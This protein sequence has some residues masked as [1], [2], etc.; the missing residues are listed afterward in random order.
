MGDSGITSLVHRLSQPFQDGLM[1]PS[2]NMSFL[3]KSIQT[4]VLHG[5][6]SFQTGVS[7][8]FTEWSHLDKSL[9][10][11]VLLEP[12]NKLHITALDVPQCFSLQSLA[13]HVI[14]YIKTQSLV[15]CYS[16]VGQLAG[17]QKS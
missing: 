9:N 3:D 10:M 13:P 4:L 14:T 5:W 12:V 1:V 6:C 2:W 11:Q 8:S 15:V 16:M 17:Y 7:A